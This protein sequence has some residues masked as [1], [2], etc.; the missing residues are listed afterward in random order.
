MFIL[1]LLGLFISVVIAT[2]LEIFVV[3][4]YTSNVL[5]LMTY[6]SFHALV[7]MV[8][9]EALIGLFTQ[10]AN[11]ATTYEVGAML[12]KAHKKEKLLSTLIVT[13]FI[14]ALLSYVLLVS[15]Q[16]LFA[17]LLLVVTMIVLVLYIVKLYRNEK[18][19]LFS[20]E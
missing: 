16:P 13:A 9:V 8:L 15:H 18:N 5:F 20:Q 3:S 7:M 10:R 2:V 19:D 4:L 14:T 11:M 1:N 17:W 6:W 12:S